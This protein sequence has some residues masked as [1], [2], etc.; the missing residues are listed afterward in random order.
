MGKDQPTNAI[1]IPDE[2]LMNK[3][4]FIRGHKIMLDSDLAELYEVETKRLKEQVRR[5]KERFPE[6]FMFELTSEEHQQLKVQL[7]QTGRGEHSKYP[8]FA[9][10]EHGVLMLSSVLNSDRAIKVN[11]QVMRIYIR[12]REMMMLHKDILQRLE[13]IERK[14]NGQDNQIMVVFEYLKQFEQSKQQELEQKNRPKIGFKPPK[15]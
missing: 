15:E 1:A 3:I 8:P 9:F 11:I 2:V 12:I 6:D 14:L 4:Y 5:N 7:G 13:N 10:T